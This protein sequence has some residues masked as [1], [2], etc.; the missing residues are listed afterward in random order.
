M[1]GPKTYTATCWRDGDRWSV[2]VPEI[3][4]T[5]RADRMSAIDAT[6][7]RLIRDA[8]GPDAASAMVEIDLRVPS[9]VMEIL[10][11]ASSAREDADRMT[12][13]AIT[14][15][16]ALA[17]RLASER[18]TVRDIAALLGISPARAQRLIG[19]LTPPQSTVALR[20]AVLDHDQPRAAKPHNSYQHEAFL[21]RGD[22]D[23]LAG[24]VPFVEE[25]IALGQSVM[26]AVAEPRLD[27]LRGALGR[28]A[29]QVFFVDM[30][31]LG[32]N[33]ARIIPGWRRFV[34]E[35]SGPGRPVRGIGEPVWAGRRPVEVIE[36]QLHEALLNL[37]VEPDIP[38]WLRCPYDVDALDDSVIEEAFR[39]H[40]A[41]V[42]VGGYRGST[43]YGGAHHADL[44]FR[45]ELPDPPGGAAHLSFAADDLPAVRRRVISDAVDAGLDSLRI[46]DLSTAVTEIATNSAAHGSADLRVWRDEDAL[47]FEIT[48]DGRLDDPLV[49]RR[50]PSD[51]DGMHGI[52]LANQVCDLVQVR[53]TTRG[54]AVR[55]LTWL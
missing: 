14:L 6:A 30:R 5:A 49:G 45:T 32:S 2:R 55:V 26:V 34:D 44:A 47:I 38:L 25:A 42:E 37:A 41:L 53:A 22:Q 16:R 39:S 20:R 43:S 4:R 17:H 23:F 1:A 31:E 3:D 28:S 18:F 9:G 46:R 24:S 33:P 36:C 27:L 50:A 7:R 29:E 48:D 51:E 12:V 35:H 21:Y 54:T 15:R 10:D 13:E 11:A 40:P 52:W 19:D 8:G